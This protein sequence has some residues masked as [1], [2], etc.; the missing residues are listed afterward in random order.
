M[1]TISYPLWNIPLQKKGGQIPRRTL[2]HLDSMKNDGFDR[3]CLQMINTMTEGRLPVSSMTE[4]VFNL[5][6]LSTI[7]IL[8]I[9]IKENERE[10][11]VYSQPALRYLQSILRMLD[12]SVYYSMYFSK[13]AQLLDMNLFICRNNECSL[14]ERI[15]GVGIVCGARYFILARNRH[16]CDIG[17]NRIDQQLIKQVSK[18]LGVV[19]V[20]LLDYI[21]ANGY[22]LCSSAL[23]GMLQ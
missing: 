12:D 16:R 9:E 5:K 22:D 18:G 6:V 10:K 8:N 3:I 2:E 14:A 17:P 7:P 13:D 4:A 15:I 20:V 11:P 21:F 19:N 23:G 1:N